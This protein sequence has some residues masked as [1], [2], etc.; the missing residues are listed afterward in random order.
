VPHSPFTRKVPGLAIDFRVSSWAGHSSRTDPS[1]HELVDL[2]S[3][4]A[5]QRN[6]IRPQGLGF[7]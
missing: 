6:G 2:V 5:Y 4:H 3:A 1:E 7:G